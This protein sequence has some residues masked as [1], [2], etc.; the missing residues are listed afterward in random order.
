MRQLSNKTRKFVHAMSCSA[1]LRLLLCCLLCAVMALPLPGQDNPYKIK[2]SLYT[3][4][5]EGHTNLLRPISL[6]WADSLSRQAVREGDQKAECLGAVLRL[7]HFTR[8]SDR[9]DMEREAENLRRV[10]RRNDFPRYYYYAYQLE[11]VWLINHGMLVSALHR[12]EQMRKEA[13]AEND[14]YGIFNCLRIMGQIYFSRMSNVQALD[15]FQQALDYQLNYLPLESPADSYFSL[16]RAYSIGTH[17][18]PAKGLEYAILAEKTSKVMQMKIQAVELQAELLYQ[19]KRYQEFRDTYNRMMQLHRENKTLPSAHYYFAQVEKAILDQDYQQAYAYVDSIG[20]PI[21]M[22]LY[23]VRILEKMGRYKE[24]FELERRRESMR[25]SVQQQLQ[26]MDLAEFNAQLESEQLKH[27]NMLLDLQNSELQLKQMQQQI[28]LERSISENKELALQNRDLELQQ[29]KAETSLQQAESEREKLEHQQQ[30]NELERQIMHNRYRTTNVIVLVG[31]LTLLMLLLI[32]YVHKRSRTARMLKAQ[33]QELHQARGQME[34]ALHE[35][36][37][38][39]RRAEQ[40]N[41]MKTM[42]IQNMSHEIRTPL[43][44]IVGF[45]QILADQQM[46]LEETE[47]KEFSQII[48]HNSELLTTLVDDLLALSELESGKYEIIN[49]Q[50]H[51]N[52]LCRETLATVDHRCPPHVRLCFTS[53]VGDDFTVTTDSRRV[54]EVLVNL[55]VNAEKFTEKGE[56]RLHLSLTEHPGRLTFSVTDTGRGI[57]A[58]QAEEIFKRFT[59]LDTFVQGNGLGLSICRLIADCLHAEIK[60]DTAYTEGARF[61]FILPL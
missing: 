28:E 39:K 49:Q 18:N 23:K 43:N 6:M 53:E 1:H 56:I 32:V 55:L 42:F 30:K 24:A 26:T 7:R 17:P 34:N 44:S 22:M 36:E 29:L 3:L 27:E 45:T 31:V 9:Q 59:K 51:C 50:V 38:Q 48:L 58:G 41:T 37:E 25:D 35:A 21:D 4:Y 11:I 40:A 33:N 54:R 2:N 13:Y 5:M 15:Y 60:V 20:H 61:V 16:A 12:C 46:D 10:S 8:G 52:V 57:P 47:R 14:P 19:L